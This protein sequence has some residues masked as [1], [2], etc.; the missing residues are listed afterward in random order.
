MTTCACA[1]AVPHCLS[2]CLPLGCIYPGMS[3]I[4]LHSVRR[5]RPARANI[6]RARTGRYTDNDDE[7][8]AATLLGAEMDEGGFAQDEAAAPVRPILILVYVYT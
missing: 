8:E 2:S 6:G 4:P 7:E 1:V 5:T 3:E